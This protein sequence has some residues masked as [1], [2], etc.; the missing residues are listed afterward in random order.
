M[1]TEI[2]NKW[3]KILQTMKT[4]FD[5]TDV[6]FKTWLLPLKPYS[7]ENDVLTII[8]PGEKMGLNYIERKYFFEFKVTISEFINHEIDIKFISALDINSSDKTA[9]K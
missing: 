2:V 5:I 3:D 6:S 1:F 9:V 7:L 4:E 8:G